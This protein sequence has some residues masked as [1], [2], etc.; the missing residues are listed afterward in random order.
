[1]A[2]SI[3][4]LCA[5]V[6]ETRNL[7]KETEWVEFKVN[8]SK[9]ETIGQNISALANSATLHSKE[10][11]YLVFGIDDKTHAVVGTTFNPHK[12]KI[13]NEELENWLGV[14][15]DPRINLVLY[16]FE[17]VPGTALALIEIDAAIGY[18]VSFEG[19]KYIRVGSYTKPMH[20]HRGKEKALWA[21]LENKVFEHG[22]A[23]DSLSISEILTLIDYAAGFRRL[24]IPLPASPQ[25]IVDKLLDEAIIV[26]L[27]GQYAITNLGAMLLATNIGEF[28]GLKRKAL[29]VIVYKG[30]DKRETVSEQKGVKGYAVGLDNVVKYV[31]DN[32]PSKEVLVNATLT[33]QYAYPPTAI[34]EMIAN[35]LIHQDFTIG[36]A[37]PM[38]EIFENRMEISNPGAPL[39]DIARIIDH[40]P[41][42]RNEA[43]AGIMARM[44]LCEERGSGV[45]KMVIECEM[46]Q[47]PA[48]EFK[49][50]DDFTRATLFTH[51]TLRDMTKEDKMRATY[52]HAVIKY[53]TDGYMTN[54]TLRERFGI[55]KENYPTASNIIRLTLDAGLIKTRDVETSTKYV[56]NW[57]A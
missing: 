20:A 30:K 9:P 5:L 50:E 43:L 27:R 23:K 52:Y 10:K 18:P 8:N 31:L 46:N 33:R 48:P 57:A 16:H 2:Y 35:A 15:L 1:M 47:L 21:K 12:K 45:D 51:R 7:P 55:S 53:L 28:D 26:K 24:S 32:I 6:D 41:R 36:G 39:I 42:S 54:N 49:V 4:Q 11:A 17:Y 13:G 56:P 14:K 29:R 22:I 19:E 3:E 38:I 44:G 37:G 25:G 34:R 40:S